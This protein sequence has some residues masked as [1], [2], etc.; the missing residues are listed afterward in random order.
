VSLSPKALEFEDVLSDLFV[1]AS[2]FS[3]SEIFYRPSDT[4]HSSV[5]VSCLRLS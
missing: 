3:P 2:P 4:I 5:E 1:V